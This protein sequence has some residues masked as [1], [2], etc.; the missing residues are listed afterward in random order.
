MKHF[1]CLNDVHCL[2]ANTYRKARI[3]DSDRYKH[4]FVQTL[5]EL[6]AELGCRIIDYVHNN[7][8]KQGLVAQRGDWPWSR[9]AGEVLLLEGQF[10]SDYGPDSL[11]CNRER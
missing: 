10:C 2:T 1:Y 6:R 4:K 7:P 11:R 5:D 9:R 3:F 8:V